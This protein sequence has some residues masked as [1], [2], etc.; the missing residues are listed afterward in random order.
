[1]GVT[2]V[3]EILKEIV[4]NPEVSIEDCRPQ[5]IKK[6]RPLEMIIRMSFV[7]ISK[8]RMTYNILQFI[9]FDNF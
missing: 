9:V 3:H 1:M 6:V 7:I 8:S 2:D 4:K 5:K